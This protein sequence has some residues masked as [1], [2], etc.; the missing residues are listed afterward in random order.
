MI[1]NMMIKL[2]GIGTE[3]GFFCG[4]VPSIGGIDLTKCHR[5]PVFWIRD[6]G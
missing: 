3:A 4:C 5:Y 1:K 6:A 2:I